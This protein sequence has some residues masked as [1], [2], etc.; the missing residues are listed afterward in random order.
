MPVIATDRWLHRYL[1]NKIGLLDYDLRL[2]KNI[3]GKNLMTYFSHS[4]HDQIHQ[5]LLQNGLFLPDSS[6]EKTIQIMCAN[7]FW[8][9]AETELTQ[10]KHEWNGP[11]IPVFIFPSNIRNDQLRVD[12]GGKSGLAHQDKMFLF[13]CG[14]TSEKDLQALVTHEYNHVC[15]LNY[16]NLAEKNIR[17][18]DAMILEGLAELAVLERFKKGFLATWTSLYPIEDAFVQWEKNFKSNLDVKKAN[19]FHNELMYGNDTIP[20]WM[21]YNIGFH[22]VTSFAKKAEIDMNQM[23]QLPSK[24]ILEESGFPI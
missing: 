17:L 4:W 2:Q 10:L 3:F 11:D 5:H 21:G 23:L 16:L 24:T 20:K 12:L 1:K 19:T 15:R 18:L 7:R 14:T 8:E 13:I 22:L 9:I 6:D